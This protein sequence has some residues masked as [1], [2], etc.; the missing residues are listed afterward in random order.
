MQANKRDEIAV[1]QTGDIVA[2]VG[3]KEVATGDTITDR[4][5]K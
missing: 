1:A 3:L 2:F 5:H 4:R